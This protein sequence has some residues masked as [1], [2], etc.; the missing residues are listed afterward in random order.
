MNSKRTHK[1]V[2]KN[3]YLEF[4]EPTDRPEGDV[5]DL[6]EDPYAYLD[7]VEVS[8]PAERARLDAAI[9]AGWAEIEAGKGIPAEQVMA[10]LRSR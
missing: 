10:R 6:F 4:R 1:A 2:V 9:R 3:G 5:V 8:D 7:K